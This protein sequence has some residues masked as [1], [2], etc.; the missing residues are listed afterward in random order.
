MLIP[1]VDKLKAENLR[2]VMN[3][4]EPCWQ[5]AHVLKALLDQLRSHE[6]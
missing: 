2:Q 3:L 5:R 1:M 6:V 4:L